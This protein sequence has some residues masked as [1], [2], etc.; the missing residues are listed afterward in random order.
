MFAACRNL[1]P[2]SARSVAVFQSLEKA[3]AFL[4]VPASERPPSAS[5]AV[6]LVEDFKG[7]R[8]FLR[9]S[10]LR[11]PRLQIVG[12]AADGLQALRKAEDLQPDLI[13]LDVDLPS[14]SGIE[15][16]RRIS[17]V[18]PRARILFVGQ[19]G[20]SSV[21]REA[22]QAGAA[23]YVHKL[24]VASDLQPAIEA[25][26]AGRRFVSRGL[27]VSLDEEILSSHR[28]PSGQPS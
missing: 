9:H 12:E 21:V 13:L 17:S 15:V 1:D 3:L 19:V 10:V 11:I 27:G 18:A 23:G 28:E 4:G 20:H 6:L 22:L 16:A 8:M 7:F 26:L 25:V 2:R 5:T 14:L 24:H